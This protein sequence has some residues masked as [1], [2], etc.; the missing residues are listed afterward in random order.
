M[1]KSPLLVQMAFAHAH[2]DLPEQFFSHAIWTS[3]ASEECRNQ[4]FK[5]GMIDKDDKGTDKLRFWVD[6]V[7]NIPWPEANFIIPLNPGPIEWVD[8]RVKQ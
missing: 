1:K 2:T 8:N 3:P 7:C 6:H 5:G 4:L